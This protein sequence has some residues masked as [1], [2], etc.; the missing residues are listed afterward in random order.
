MANDVFPPDYDSE[1]GMV[2]A[3]I[4][5]VEQQDFNA[6]GDPNYLFRDA[7]LNA[8]LS[9]YGSALVPVARI[10][11]AAADALAAIAV[12]EALVSKVIKTEDLQTDGAKVANA[13][14]AAAIRLRK[15]ADADEERAEEEDGFAI[16]DFRPMPP[17]HLPTSLQGYP[18]GAE[19]S[20]GT[21]DNA[22]IGRWV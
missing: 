5:D 1:L 13:L 22:G 16:V 8:Y 6:E 15:D 10:K 3:L 2:R 9:L 7:H 11:R 4:P 19:W 14:L 18:Y 21:F 20:A 12:S 17:D